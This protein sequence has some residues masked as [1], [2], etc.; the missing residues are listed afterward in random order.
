MKELKDL[1]K[2]LPKDAHIRYSGVT[3]YGEALIQ[4]ALTRFSLY[5]PALPASSQ[6]P[7]LRIRNLL[8]KNITLQ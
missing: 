4:T 6:S 2:I 7:G 8:F 5:L 3:G 1:Y